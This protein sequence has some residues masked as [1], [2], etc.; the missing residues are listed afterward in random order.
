MK[1][2]AYSSIIQSGASSSASPTQVPIG[3]A[4]DACWEIGCE[5]LAYP[6]WNAFAKAFFKF[7]VVQQQ[8]GQCR[9]RLKLR[10]ISTAADSIPQEFSVAVRQSVTVET[11]DVWRGYAEHVIKNQL[12]IVRLTKSGCDGIPQVKLPSQAEHA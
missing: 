10:P 11:E 9:N 8:V 7:E 6:D 2:A 5:I 3:P 12:D 4:C 1:W